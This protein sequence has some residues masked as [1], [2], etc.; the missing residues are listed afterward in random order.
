MDDS[1]Y[2][3]FSESDRRFIGK[4]LDVN[5]EKITVECLFS[6]KVLYFSPS[7]LYTKEHLE[8]ISIHALPFAY[9]G[10]CAT[11]S[12]PGHIYNALNKLY[13]RKG[14]FSS[15]IHM[16]GINESAKMYLTSV[17]Q[18]TLTNDDISKKVYLAG[19]HLAVLPLH[20]RAFE[21]GLIS[22]IFD[23]HRDYRLDK[24]DIINHGNF[25]NFLPSLEN[26]II[27]GYRDGSF[28]NYKGCRIFTYEQK[29]EFLN[30]INIEKQ[31]GKRFYLD[32]DMD[33]LNPE[34][35]PAVSCPIT[36]GLN[37]DILTSIIQLIGFRNFDLL[38]VEEYVPLL[39]N[40]TCEM[41]IIN[42]I[43]KIIEGWNG[44][45]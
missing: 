11:L 12:G 28:D 30:T 41:T 43:I 40:G 31:A 26:M 9:N 23:A 3:V 24:Q 14:L 42:L 32:I 13:G 2:F 38:S 7:L 16:Q 33:V 18:K 10:P 22:I 35:F 20:Y 27:F 36:R 17:Y 39:D 21:E 8:K 6:G 4:L 5:N 37:F 29:S 34:V 1:K 44:C 25:L 15:A 19:N 45:E